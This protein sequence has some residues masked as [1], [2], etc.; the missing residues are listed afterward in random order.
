MKFS[1]TPS[2]RASAKRAS[3]A[4]QRTQIAVRMCRY[5]LVAGLLRWRASRWLAMTAF[6][7]TGKYFV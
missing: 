5:S 2:L 7:F 1:I 3:E 6:C 4:T